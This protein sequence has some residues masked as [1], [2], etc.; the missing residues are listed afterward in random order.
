MNAVIT[1]AY[2]YGVSTRK[3][4]DLV[5]ALGAASGVPE[6]E[7]SWICASLDSDVAA[8]TAVTSVSKNSRTYS[9]TPPTARARV[10]GDKT[11]KGSRVSSQ[12]S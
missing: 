8:S 5:K 12:G 10:G 4:D 3:V 1:W 6:S 11:G 2:V 7:A 9:S